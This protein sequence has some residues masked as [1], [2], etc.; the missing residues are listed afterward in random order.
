MFV[1]MYLYIYFILFLFL[2]FNL[3]LMRRN[4]NLAKPQRTFLR[5]PKCTVCLRA[6]SCAVLNQVMPLFFNFSPFSHLTNLLL[7]CIS[8][9]SLTCHQLM[10][11]SFR[12]CTSFFQIFEIFRDFTRFQIFFIFIYK[13]Q[14]EEPYFYFMEPRYMF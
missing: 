1:H 12:N 7:F 11:F 14:G 8:V 5:V 3:S 2:V 10:R 6:P 4:F 9:R 13:F